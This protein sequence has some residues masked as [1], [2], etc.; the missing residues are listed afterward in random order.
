MKKGPL[1]NTFF[2]AILFVIFLWQTIAATLKYFEK[3]TIMS[4]STSDEGAILFPSITVC[5]KYLHGNTDIHNSSKSVSDK[6]TMLQR[7]LWTK[8]ETFFFFTHHNM[9]NMSFPCTTKGDIGT[10]PGK[11]CSFP[12]I[13]R[14][15]GNYWQR[16]KSK[17]YRY[18]SYYCVLSSWQSNRTNSRI[19]VFICKWLLYKVE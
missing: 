1:I 2:L 19:T 12:Y 14:K 17:M 18:S 9:F 16:V 7:N 5:K 4:T 13:K 3:T 6:I 8:N 11:P 15:Y 10:D